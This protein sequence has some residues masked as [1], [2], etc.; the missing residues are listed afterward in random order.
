MPDIPYVLHK[1][2]WMRGQ[3]IWPNGKRYLWTDAFGVLL[4]VS[5]YRELGEARYL[6]EAEGGAARAAGRH[7]RGR[8]GG[9]VSRRGR[10][11][12]WPGWIGSPGASAGSASARR[13]IG[14]G[15]TFITWRC[16]S[17]PAPGSA[18]LAPRTAIGPARSFG[19]FTPRSTPE[20]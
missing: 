6:D 4:L 19:R 17:S 14:T 18:A 1:L 7:R 11:G 16:G 12:S 13:R 15:N 9:A 10:G 2:E 20:G 5:L 8:R 3:R